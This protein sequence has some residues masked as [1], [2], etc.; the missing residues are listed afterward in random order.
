MLLARPTVVLLLVLTIRTVFSSQR[1]AT[2][3]ATTSR[4]PPSTTRWS[5]RSH[6]VVVAGVC[7]EVVRQ[8]VRGGLGRHDLVKHGR[9]WPWG[10]HQDQ[11]RRPRAS[12][13]RAGAGRGLVRG[14]TRRH[15]MRNVTNEYRIIRN[16]ATVSLQSRRRRVRRPRAAPPEAQA[17]ASADTA[18][19][20]RS[21]GRTS[22]WSGT[23]ADR[24][25][26]AVS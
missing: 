6:V 10:A 2:L 18:P 17:P 19:H 9:A 26:R 15:Q 25:P 8:R 21:A 3:W 1:L 13:A 16:T 7:V 11:P 5:R 20:T 23:R 22:S 24:A 14:Y 12:T 4:K